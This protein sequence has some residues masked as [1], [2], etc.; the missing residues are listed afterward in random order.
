[1][2]W[3]KRVEKKTPVPE[4]LDGERLD[5]AL[6][7]LLP[8]HSRRGARALISSGAVYLNGRRCLKV[9][10][11]VR[12]GD[13]ITVAG[14]AVREGPAGAEAE[15]AII[16][17]EGGLVAVDKPPLF[18]STPTRSS[19]RS[20]QQ[21]VADVKGVK[22][23]NVH[24]VNRLD[25]PVSGVLLFACGREAAA[26]MERL[27]GASAIEKKYLA[28]VVGA[29]PEAEGRID[30]ALS[31]EKGTA[32]ADPCGKE[33]VTRFK[34]MKT[35]GKFSLLEVDPVTGRMHQIRVHLKIAGF[36]I[37]G[38]R[39]YGAPPF[40]A[41]RPLL[42]CAE[43]AFTLEEGGERVVIKSPLPPDFEEFSSKAGGG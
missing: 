17:D 40:L 2:A 18:P 5:K 37:V 43:L 38:D 27:K 15:P 19:I 13:F 36:P 34:V 24:P 6:S 28:W 30:V 22:I 42:H 29:P 21:F 1:M 16:H 25:L 9:S 32:F 7:E 39:K 26:M 23:A 11:P 20:A 3:E 8:E 35:A 14:C 33:S 10:R 41:K 31:S 4:N 12:S